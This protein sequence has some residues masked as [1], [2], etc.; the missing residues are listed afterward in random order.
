MLDK[1]LALCHRYSETNQMSSLAEVFISWICAI[2]VC[3]GCGVADQSDEFAGGGV[4]Q[5][6]LCHVDVYRLWCCSGTVR[7]VR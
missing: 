6:D 2:L 1:Q 7:P 4:H 3:I 5:L